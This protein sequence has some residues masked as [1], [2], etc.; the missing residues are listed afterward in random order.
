M[1]DN[2]KSKVKEAL[3]FNVYLRESDHKL[4]AWI[5]RDEIKD[6]WHDDIINLLNMD[7]LTNW[8]SIARCRR[9]IQEE[10]PELRGSNYE[11]KQKKS[12]EV[13]MDLTNYE[14]EL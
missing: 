8:E 10:I 5:W 7:K 13:G 14:P 6:M 2:L 3:E 9:K 11:D 1:K 12:V 4:V